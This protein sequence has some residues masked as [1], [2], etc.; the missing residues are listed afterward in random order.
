MASAP[1]TEVRPAQCRYSG[2]SLAGI[3]GPT[4]VIPNYWHN[5]DEIRSA[6]TGGD[7]L[8]TAPEA[9]DG[10]SRE[11][12]QGRRWF[13]PRRGGAA[14]RRRRGAVVMGLAQIDYSLAVLAAAVV[15][16]LCPALVLA[17]FLMSVLPE[18]LPERQARLWVAGQL[19]ERGHRTPAG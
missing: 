12:I 16:L 7:P 1:V 5:P 9:T 6:L 11:R 15:F 2:I 14:A 10:P 8:A 17:L 3:A 19:R 18:T 13:T 4:R